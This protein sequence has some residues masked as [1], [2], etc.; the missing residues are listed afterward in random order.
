MYILLDAEGFIFLCINIYSY[1]IYSYHLKS[2]HSTAMTFKR[3]FYGKTRAAAYLKVTSEGKGYRE[4]AKNLKISVPSVH[5]CYKERMGQKKNFTVGKRGRPRTILHQDTAQFIRTF[6]KLRDD[7][8][9]R[10]VKTVI[11]ESGLTR[12]NYRP[13][14]R[15]LNT[16]GHKKLSIQ[17]GQIHKKSSH[18]TITSVSTFKE[19]TLDQGILGS[20]R[21]FLRNCNI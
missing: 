18:Q 11:I 1:H 16:A 6:R 12:G 8:Q 21:N 20:I 2:P 5:R 3:K 9:N 15:L 19:F 14:V 10:T 4:V 17:E 13:F 7:G